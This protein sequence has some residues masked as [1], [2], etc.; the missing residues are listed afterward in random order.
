MRYDKV[1]RPVPIAEKSRLVALVD[2]AEAKRPCLV[3]G[4][5]RRKTAQ[6]K[7]KL[8]AL[9]DTFDVR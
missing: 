1:D 4:A 5:W 2:D 6:A 7:V 9:F 8:G 3:M